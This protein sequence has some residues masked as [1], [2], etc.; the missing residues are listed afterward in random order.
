MKFRSPTTTKYLPILSKSE[1]QVHAH[2]LEGNRVAGHITRSG[3]PKAEIKKKKRAT[4]YWGLL[5]QAQV[6]AL[7]SHSS[8]ILQQLRIRMESNDA[9][10]LPFLFPERQDSAL[11]P[12]PWPNRDL[13]AR[14][15]RTPKR[16]SDQWKA[17]MRFR[18]SGYWNKRGDLQKFADYFGVDQSGL[19]EKIKESQKQWI[20]AAEGAGSSQGEPSSP[21][22]THPPDCSPPSRGGDG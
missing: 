10:K 9:N 12:N 22:P 5:V 11:F 2:S 7:C 20:H 13:P 18:N 16:D 4:S 15:H 8:I 14:K 17:V 3:S 6:L 21:T 19:S 1:F